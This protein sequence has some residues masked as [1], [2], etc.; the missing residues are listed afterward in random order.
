VEVGGEGWRGRRT[1]EAL[2]AAGSVCSGKK[3]K[4]DDDE[5]GG[6]TSWLV[7]WCY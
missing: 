6:N 4:E 5:G 7:V 2:V 3:A 1:G